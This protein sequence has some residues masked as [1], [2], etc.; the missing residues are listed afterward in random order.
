MGY[1]ST[2]G[3]SGGS[4]AW[5]SV[6]F[7][8][9]YEKEP[10]FLYRSVAMCLKPASHLP[11]SRWRKSSGLLIWVGYFVECS[12]K[13]DSRKY[14]FSV[15]PAEIKV[16]L[17]SDTQIWTSWVSESLGYLSRE[18]FVWVFPREAE[19]SGLPGD[20]F[21]WDQGRDPDEKIPNAFAES[22]LFLQ[23]LSTLT[24]SKRTWRSL[25]SG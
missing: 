14:L 16:G 7:L 4:K 3:P 1:S 24:F 5:D 21:F 25:P 20:G 11:F 9:T 15:T 12:G 8:N 13:N 17:D 18:W 2:D 19:K 22:F 6:I 23:K 10:P